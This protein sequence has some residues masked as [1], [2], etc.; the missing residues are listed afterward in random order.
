MPDQ[1]LK[2]KKKLEKEKKKTKIKKIIREDVK[3]KRKRG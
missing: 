3:K 2:K 1:K